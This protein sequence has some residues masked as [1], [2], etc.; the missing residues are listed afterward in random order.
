MVYAQKSA[1]YGESTYFGED[2]RIVVLLPSHSGLGFG[3]MMRHMIRLTPSH[4]LV[5]LAAKHLTRHAW[6]A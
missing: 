6:G 3:Q 1:H 2:K 5:V 4:K